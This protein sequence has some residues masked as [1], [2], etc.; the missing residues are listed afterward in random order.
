MSRVRNRWT[1]VGM[2]PLCILTCFVL[3]AGSALC[4]GGAVETGTW[5][6]GV[7]E[8]GGDRPRWDTLVAEMSVAG[9]RVEGVLHSPH[10]DA[11]ARLNP[12]VALC[13]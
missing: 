9:G 10:G 2:N 13:R 8:I 4:R 11:A 5:S 6:G 1:T 3:L 12:Y 7:G